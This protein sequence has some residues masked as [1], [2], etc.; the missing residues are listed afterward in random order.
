MIVMYKSSIVLF[1]IDLS[2][3]IEKKYL[4]ETALDCTLRDLKEADL[5]CTFWK[6]FLGVSE[7]NRKEYEPYLYSVALGF[8]QRIYRSVLPG[9]SCSVLISS[10]HEP[11]A[12][13]LNNLMPKPHI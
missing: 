3:K 13:H 9:T 1:F 4:E 7:K 10:W 6:L 11:Q 5:P 8:I 12:L 2:H